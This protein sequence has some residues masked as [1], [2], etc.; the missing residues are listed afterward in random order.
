MGAGAS[1]DRLRN[2]LVLKAYNARAKDQTIVQQ[3]GPFVQWNDDD[4]SAYLHVSDIQKCLS[5][6]D[7]QTNKLLQ[8]F[9]LPLQLDGMIDYNCFISFIE[10]GGANRTPR[11]VPCSPAS[12]KAYGIPAPFTDEAEKQPECAKQLDMG[13]DGAAPAQPEEESALSTNLAPNA[14]T[15]KPKWRPE[16]HPGMW[17]KREIVREERII[18]IFQVDETGQGVTH[19]ETQRQQVEVVHMENV[20]GEFAHKETTNFEAFQ[21]VNNQ[22]VA[23]ETGDQH[24]IHLRSKDDEVEL[25]ESTMPQPVE[26]MQ[27]PL[28]RSIGD[29]NPERKIF[30]VRDGDA[31]T[32][33]GGS[34]G[35]VKPDRA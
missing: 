7:E 4:N 28:V 29:K 8:R 10:F 14:K 6:T 20:D 32:G 26:E 30:T 25:F 11:N 22:L 19:T 24:H 23:H 33:I 27:M 12:R 9:V 2:V 17:K 1:L 34:D 3:F 35:P 21:E 18:E 5:L 13:D 16:D 31:W 15:W